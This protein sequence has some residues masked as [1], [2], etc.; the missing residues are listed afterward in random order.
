MA[1]KV[2]SLIRK[3]VVAA[4]GEE[5]RAGVCPRRGSLPDIIRCAAAERGIKL[6]E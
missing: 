4:T 6:Q 2:A 3:L 1:K 5:D